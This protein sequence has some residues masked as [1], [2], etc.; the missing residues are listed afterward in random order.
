MWTLIIIL[1]LL[2][3]KV[4]RRSYIRYKSS[5]ETFTDYYFSDKTFSTAPAWDAIASVFVAIIL[6][7]ML[8]FLVVIMIKYLP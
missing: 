5:G 6:L 8:I 3:L 1:S 2:A 4:V 7:T